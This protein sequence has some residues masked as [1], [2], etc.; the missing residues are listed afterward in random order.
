MIELVP[1]D[2]RRDLLTALRI[3]SAAR[4]ARGSDIVHPGGLQ[5]LF[6]RLG[7]PGFAVHMVGFE[8]SGFVVNDTGYVIVGCAPEHASSRLEIVAAVEERLR[9]DGVPAM[10]FST[11]EDDH[12]L[13]EALAARGYAPS[14]T[15]GH[16]LVY[17][18]QTS[19][20][21]GTDALRWRLAK[22]QRVAERV[23]QG[24]DPR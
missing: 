17:D 22:L 13:R 18:G 12:A 6:R 2:T 24:L 14:G 15:F 19:G 4:A 23:V 5:W 21:G 16:E 10:E 3:A 8:P 20:E 7:L 1:C 9:T 11:W